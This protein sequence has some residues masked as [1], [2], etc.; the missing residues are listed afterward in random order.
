MKIKA[1]CP[2]DHAPDMIFRHYDTTGENL[3]STGTPGNCRVC[4]SDWIGYSTRGGIYPN[5]G[6]GPIQIDCKTWIQEYIVLDS[7]G[8]RRMLSFT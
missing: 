2:E 3:P 6:W 5:F 4:V 7:P 1:G 8:D